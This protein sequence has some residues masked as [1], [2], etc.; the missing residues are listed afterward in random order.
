ML[1]YSRGELFTTSSP[2]FTFIG[3]KLLLDVI[4][5]HWLVFLQ[6]EILSRKSLLPFSSAISANLIYIY[7]YLFAILVQ[8]IR[9]QSCFPARGPHVSNYIMAL[10]RSRITEGSPSALLP[11]L[12]PTLLTFSLFISNS[13]SL[14]L[15]L[16]FSHPYPPRLSHVLLTIRGESGDETGKGY[17]IY[18]HYCRSRKSK[19]T[20]RI[21]FVK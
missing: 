18:Q 9:F 11:C 3:C 13:V 15:S 21:H 16:P 17:R 14:A 2:S 20:R 7:I 12:L 19:S 1:S 5:E 4:L 6:C 8:L 10:V